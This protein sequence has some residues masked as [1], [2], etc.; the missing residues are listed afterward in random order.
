MCTYFAPLLVDLFEAE[1][2]QKLL[3]D[4]NKPLAVAL[5]STYRYIDD[6]LSI[7]SDLFHSYFYSTFPSEL[8]IKVTTD[9]TE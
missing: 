3:H 4:K 8:E 5:N 7:N 1:F 2:I 9:I 6:V